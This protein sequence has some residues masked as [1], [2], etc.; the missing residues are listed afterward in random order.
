MALGLFKCLGVFDQ[1]PT[2]ILRDK[3]QEAKDM[4]WNSAAAKKLNSHWY[5]A[6]YILGVAYDERGS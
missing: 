5:L 4:F 3:L 1:W 2:H 6:E